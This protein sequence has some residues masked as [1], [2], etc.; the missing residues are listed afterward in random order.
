MA[1]DQD[2]PKI[3]VDDD[4][5]TQAEQEK[6]RLSE[7]VEQKSQTAQ[8][9]AQAAQAAAGGPKPGPRQLPQANFQTFVS[10]LATQ[11][12]MALGG[13]RDPES[14]QPMVDLDLAK[15]HIDC[16]SLLEEKTKGNLDE[17]E[18]DTLDHVLYEIRMHYVQ[19]AQQIG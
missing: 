19:I 16:L 7:Q 14:G 9:G 12:M 15:F 5:K 17:D 11:A 8:A 1:E 4:W 2:K 13:M 10:T 18:K 3:I 6:K